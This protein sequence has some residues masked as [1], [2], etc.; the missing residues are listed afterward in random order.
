MAN[1]NTKRTVAAALAQYNELS[2]KKLKTWSKGLSNLEEAINELRAKKPGRKPT[3]FTEAVRAA[4]KD[5]RSVRNQ[6]RKAGVKK[7]PH[8]YELN[9]DTRAFLTA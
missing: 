8:G 6:L 7:G 9:K 3:D 4:G 2:G 5:P 1:T